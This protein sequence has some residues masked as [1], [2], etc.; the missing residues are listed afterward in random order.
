MISTVHVFYSLSLLNCESSEHRIDYDM[1][2]KQHV[3]HSKWY[4]IYP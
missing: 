3:V 1:A 4:Q 2:Q